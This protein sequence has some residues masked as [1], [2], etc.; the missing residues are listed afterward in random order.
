MLGRWGVTIQFSVMGK[1]KPFFA[2]WTAFE[3]I[4]FDAKYCNI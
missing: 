3:L 4:F 2:V 1:N